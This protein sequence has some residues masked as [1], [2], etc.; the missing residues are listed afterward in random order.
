MEV[1]LFVKE[2]N[3]YNG[4]V[5]TEI[6]DETIKLLIE[7]VESTNKLQKIS[8]FQDRVSSNESGFINSLNDDIFKCRRYIVC[9]LCHVSICWIIQSAR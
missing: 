6:N 8:K 7:S 2:L 5:D 3:S 9:C 1:A 4:N